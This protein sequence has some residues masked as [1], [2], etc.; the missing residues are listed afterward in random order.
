VRI[1]K[2]ELGSPSIIKLHPI[3]SFDQRGSLRSARPKVENTTRRNKEKM[4]L[5]SSFSRD[6]KTIAELGLMASNAKAWLN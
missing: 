4:Y 3:E 2:K 1:L 6:N 5:G